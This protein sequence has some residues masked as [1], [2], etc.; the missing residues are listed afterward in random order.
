MTVNTEQQVIHKVPPNL[1][2]AKNTYFSIA[3]AEVPTFP[4]QD[5]DEDSLAVTWNYDG[6]LEV[7]CWIA[8][9]I[10]EDQILSVGG[11]KCSFAL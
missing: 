4:Y 6:P 5:W 9:L 1:I 2:D 7:D 10:R 8:L 3:I 11:W